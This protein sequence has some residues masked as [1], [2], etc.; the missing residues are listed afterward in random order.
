MMY[1]KQSTDAVLETISRQLSAED[2]RLL[3]HAVVREVLGD[4][5][6]LCQNATTNA[7]MFAILG[8]C[9]H[10]MR[11]HQHRWLADGSFAAPYGYGGSGGIIHGFPEFDWSIVF[12]WMPDDEIW[13]PVEAVEGKRALSL[14]VSVPTRTRRHDQAAVHT[15]WLPHAPTTRDAKL[16]RLYGFRKSTDGWR[17]TASDGKPAAFEASLA[18]DNT[19]W[20]APKKRDNPY[21]GGNW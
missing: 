7:P 18:R 1:N 5:A 12:Q 11:P 20:R 15:V 10:W 9:S 13:S 14:R 21:E 17:C 6:F 19:Q 4:A 3:W 16:L 2:D 8:A